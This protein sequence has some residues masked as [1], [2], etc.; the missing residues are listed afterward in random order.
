MGRGLFTTK[1][2]ASNFFESYFFFLQQNPAQKTS[3]EPAEIAITWEQIERS[4]GRLRVAFANQ[5]GLIWLNLRQL[6]ST[7]T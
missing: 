4:I 2:V 3:R 5:W 6:G 1:G 7:K